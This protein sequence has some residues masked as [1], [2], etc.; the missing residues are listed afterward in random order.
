MEITSYQRAREIMGKNFFGVEEAVKHF[1][2]NPV[3]Q[4]AALLDIRAPEETLE[5]LKSTHILVVVFPLSIIEI[6][7]RV[8]SN[9]FS[10]QDWYNKE[11]FAREQGEVIWQLVCKTPLDDSFAMPW[12]EQ[13]A[14]ISKDD[15]VPSARVIVY[16]I[17]G[18][19]LATGE[20]LFEKPYVR[21]SSMDWDLQHVG[22]GRFEKNGLTV[23]S[24]WDHKRHDIVGIASV[25]KS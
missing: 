24:F 23:G 15:E 17:T 18:H 14:L 4:L 19:F 6:R 21:T 16:T 9:L 25:R 11:S 2:L 13:Q 10:S 22:V 12:Q 5:Q 3:H 1:K 7:G 20:R 8:D